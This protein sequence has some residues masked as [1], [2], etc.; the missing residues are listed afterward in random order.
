MDSKMKI[1]V[2]VI[3]PEVVNGKKNEK[4][5]SFEMDAKEMA[6]QAKSVDSVQKRL[7]EYVVKSGFCKDDELKDLTYDMKDFIQEWKKQIHIV[8]AEGLSEA[9][10]SGNDCNSR[11]TPK[12]INDLAENEIF[13]FGSNSQGHHYGG[14]AKQAVECF[15]AIMGQGHGPQGR[16]YAINSMSGLDDMKEDIDAFQTFAQAHPE[17]RF[18]V[19]LIGCGIAGY[20]PADVAPLFVGCKELANVC[21]PAEFWE[22]IGHP[23]SVPK[24]YDLERFVKAQKNDYGTALHELSNGHKCSHW[25]WYIFPQQKGLG[26]SFNSE[27]YG[28][29]GQ[30]EAKAYLAHPI[31]GKRLREC[32]EVLLTHKDKKIGS[33]MGSPIDVR[34]LKTCMKLF[35]RVSPNDIFKDVLDAFFG[36]HPK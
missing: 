34:K 8:E 28:L 33:I 31:L 29:D 5:F 15:G 13:V 11:L 21:L 3:N 23:G 17:K 35:D 27:F 4:V 26:K 22:I 1:T 20:R 32:C 6:R 16:C 10:K 14:A 24:H 18:L 25:I 2:S 9:D 12:Q 36:I 7:E 30:E 19:T